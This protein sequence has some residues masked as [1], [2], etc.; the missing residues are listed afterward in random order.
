MGKNLSVKVQDGEEDTS[1]IDTRAHE[2]RSFSPGNGLKN[3]EA[4]H[5]KARILSCGSHCLCRCCHAEM[6]ADATL[7]SEKEFGVVLI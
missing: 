5:E 4:I 3:S 1:E 2:G 7:G 6:E